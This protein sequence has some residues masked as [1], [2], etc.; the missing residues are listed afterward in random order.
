LELVEN[1]VIPRGFEGESG[2]FL[3]QGFS[4]QKSVEMYSIKEIPWN[5]EAAARRAD[6]YVTRL[7]A[8]PK[9]F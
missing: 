3:T 5:G 8:V 1:L 9:M 2:E 6:M 7:V 4:L